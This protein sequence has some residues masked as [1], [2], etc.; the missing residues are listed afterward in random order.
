MATYKKRKP[1]AYQ[2]NTTAIEN[3]PLPY[4]LYPGHYGTF[5]GFREKENAP[6]FLCSCSYGALENYLSFRLSHPIPQNLDKRRM[7]VLD[8][9]VVP[10]VLV[11]SLMRQGI[12]KDNA[13][14]KYVR[15]KDKICHE[16]NR[17]IPSYRYCHKMYGGVFKQ[18]Y[19]WYINKQ[20]YEYGILDNTILTEICPQEILDLLEMDPNSFHESRQRLAKQDFYKAYELSKEFDKQKRRVWRVIENEV[21][22]KFGHKKIGEAWTSETI[23]YYIVQSLLP[24]KT[25]LKHHR[26]DFLEGLELDIYIPDLKIGIEYQGIQHYKPVK[27]WGGEEALRK[28]Q[29]RD[30]RKRKICKSLGIKIIYFTYDEDLSEQLVYNQ[31]KPHL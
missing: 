21:R 20:A 9:F 30:I 29:E 23:L 4:V 25:I 31:L 2:E 12:H 14:L 26:P 17:Q 1:I 6:I 18:T 3:L 11:E 7:F 8:S 22:R 16:C 5:F 27:H 13:V 24:K 19:G 28:C 15:F 10:P